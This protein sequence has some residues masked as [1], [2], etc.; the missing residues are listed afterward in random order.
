VW[1]GAVADIKEVTLSQGLKGDQDGSPKQFII[2]SKQLSGSFAQ[3]R[4]GNH[5][6]W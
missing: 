3:T 5:T 6:T 4:E 1:D 2:Y